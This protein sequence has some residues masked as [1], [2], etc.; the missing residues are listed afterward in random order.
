MSEVNFLVDRRHH[1]HDHQLFDDLTSGRLQA[2]RQLADGDRVADGDGDRLFLPFKLDAAHPLGLGFPAAL[3]LTVLLG[4]LV[5]F[6]LLD[7]T[8]R[9]P[10][11]GWRSGQGHRTSHRIYRR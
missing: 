1:A 5:E 8:S 2:H 7:C 4:A 10:E 3:R 6:L 9:H 11:P